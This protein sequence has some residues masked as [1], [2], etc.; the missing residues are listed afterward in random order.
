MRK[1]L[2]AALLL[3]FAALGMAQEERRV[4]FVGNSYVYTNDLPR[5]VEN[6]AASMGDRLSCTSNAPGGCTLQQ[7]CQNQSMTLI[8]QGGWDFVVLQE[9]SQR[10]SFPQAQVEVEVFPFAE[11]LVDSVYAN[12]PCCEPMFFMTWGHKYGDAGNAPYF[13]VLGTYEGMDSMLCERYTYM[14]RSFDASLCPVGR[15]FRYLRE[16]HAD[17]DV[18][19]PDNSHPSLAGSY[20]AACAFYVLFFHRDP[21]SIA[22]S[23]TLPEATARTIRSAVR[24]VVFDSLAAWQRPEPQV[25][26]A[27][28][29]PDDSTALF[30]ASV[31]HADS[32][33][34]HFGD[35]S[36]TTAAASL[37]SILHRYSEP[38]TYDV[39]IVARRHC[40]AA[41]DTTSVTIV[42]ETPVSI[43][44]QSFSVVSVSPNPTADRLT[45]S[46]PGRG[47][48]ALA[49]YSIEGKLLALQATDASGSADLAL[50]HLPAGVYLLRVAL[51]DETLVRKVVIS[52]QR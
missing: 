1:A 24:S 37:T 25:S 40:L 4:L 45:V 17:I 15:V 47:R 42:A 18:Y 29:M 33:V 49:L 50:G 26:V 36:D 30:T 5:L 11:R 19:S 20:A 23:A 28:T 13:P 39:T 22:F 12:N 52:R 48:V 10:P 27:A 32:L 43:A 35:G 46:L 21:D 44:S 14:A 2:F 16:N 38:G 8:R 9:Q 34:W 7:H 31:Q 51:P 41:T 3:C 6:I